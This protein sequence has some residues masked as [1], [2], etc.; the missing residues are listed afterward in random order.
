MGHLV[1]PSPLVDGTLY[2]NRRLQ[3]VFLITKNFIDI[4]SNNKINNNIWCSFKE[5]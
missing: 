5:F 2:V 1:T 3:Q 4:S